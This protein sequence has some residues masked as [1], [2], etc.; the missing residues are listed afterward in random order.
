MIQQKIIE[1]PAVDTPVVTQRPWVSLV[2]CAR[3]GG[4]ETLGELLDEVI[5]DLADMPHEIIVVD[6]SADDRT[7]EIVLARARGHHAL[8]LI[9]RAAGEDL[10]SAAI[11]GWDVAR[12]EV[13]AIMEGDGRHDPRLVGRMADRM[14]RAT[15][16]VVIASRYMGAGGSGLVGYRD[17]LS[18]AGVRLAG[19]LLG[20]R[21]ADPLS[22][23]F[24]MTRAWYGSVRP[25]LSGAGSKTLID[26]VSSDRRR[27]AVLQ[28]PTA[29]R[30]RGGGAA[31]LDLRVVLDLLTHLV[32]RR[33]G[34]VVTARLAQVLLVGLTG[35]LAH[36]AVQA[37]SLGLGAPFWLSQGVAILAAMS[38]SFML[39]SALRERRPH[40]RAPGQ[41]LLS[42]YGEG[43]G[44]AF[45]SQVVAVG[46]YAL[47]VHW[48]AA[49]AAGALMGATCNYRAAERIAWRRPKPVRRMATRS[50]HAR[51]IAAMGAQGLAE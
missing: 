48:L 9:R 1:A 47:D 40:G 50:A 22:G 10:A 20:L 17:W 41:D 42:F 28:I 24:A 21:L 13:F 36:L 7:T 45:L 34:G 27:P 5:A 16:D 32:E 11:A 37:S 4:H 12:G 15:A 8:R 31:P 3:G 19:R 38:W 18:R 46:L 29:L 43:L 35:L 49:G 39:D 30:P 33:T 26:V 25:R 2:I 44:G 23:C 14:T 51:R 6:S